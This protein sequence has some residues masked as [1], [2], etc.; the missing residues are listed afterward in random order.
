ML[1]G[2]GKGKKEQ[3]INEDTLE[4]KK[5]GKEGQSSNLDTA[6]AKESVL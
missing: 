1:L 4:A 5:W 3:R 6:E 2:Y